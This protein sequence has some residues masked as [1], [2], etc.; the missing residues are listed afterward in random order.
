MIAVAVTVA[1]VGGIIAFREYNRP[2]ASTTSLKSDV[3][4]DADDL[5]NAFLGDEAAANIQFNDKVVEVRGAVRSIAPE[6][7]GRTEVI[8]ETGDPLAGIVCSFE[9][10]PPPA[11]QVGDTVALKGVCTGMLMDVVLVRCTLAS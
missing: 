8:L 9:S 2:V 1:V 7:E 3:I 10:G 4:I 5:L 11:I 6:F